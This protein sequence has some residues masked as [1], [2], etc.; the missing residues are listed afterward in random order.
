MFNDKK[1]KDL[2]NSVFNL[3]ERCRVLREKV[4]MIEV[5]LIACGLSKNSK[6]GSV[7]ISKD[8]FDA[9]ALNEYLGIKVNIV[10]S[11]TEYVKVGN[12]TKE[13]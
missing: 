1:I 2:E 13:N 8:N 7:I 11:K 12:E 6:C 4:S 3:N 10:P 9:D 5:V